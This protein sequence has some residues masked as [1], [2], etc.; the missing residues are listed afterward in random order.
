MDTSNFNLE[1][2]RLILKAITLD[3]SEDIFK[4]FT[5]EITTYM[6]PKPAE[7]INETIDFI[8]TSIEENKQGKN[9]QLVILKK[10]N[11]EFI[12]CC[13][14]H[15]I[16]EK[17][18]EF[19]IWI[20]KSAHGNGFGKEAVLALKEWSDTNLDYE[21]LL[22]PVVDEN[23]ASRKIPEALNGKLSREYDE[24]NMSGVTQRTLEYR[25]Y[26]N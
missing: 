23:I 17:T 25:I 3:Y 12:G 9:C 4:E 14:V 22:Y 7:N 15:N 5:K 26:P 6:Y 13:G 11:K 19:G 18:P 2:E 1:T 16:N 10:E 8:E 21:Y 20:K 24:K